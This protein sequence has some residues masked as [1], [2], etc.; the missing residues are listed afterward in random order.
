MT[1]KSPSVH[2]AN[3]TRKGRKKSIFLR[4]RVTSGATSVIWAILQQEAETETQK[5]QAS[6][7]EKTTRDITVE[8]RP[9]A[10]AA[11]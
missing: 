8:V 7:A 5:R 10:R 4:D 3:L 1:G 9:V 2:T 6:L 11:L